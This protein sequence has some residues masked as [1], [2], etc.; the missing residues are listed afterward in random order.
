MRVACLAG[1]TGLNMTRAHP[2]SLPATSA[3][4][5]TTSRRAVVRNLHCVAFTN[6]FRKWG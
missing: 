2:A 6:F 3:L 4:S 5:L 1:Y